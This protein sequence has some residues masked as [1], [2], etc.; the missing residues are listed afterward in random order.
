MSAARFFGDDHAP[1]INFTPDDEELIKLYLLPRV[2]GEPDPFPGL[3][4]DDD[5]AATTQPWT[6]FSR[7]H[8]PQKDALPAFFYVRTPDARS[9]RRCDGGG[10]W[11]SQRRV[12]KNKNKDDSHALLVGGEKIRWIR[13]NLNF[14]MGSGSIGWVMREYSIPDHPFL[15][16]CRISF[17]G[18]GQKRMRVPDDSSLAAG[19]PATKRARVA[20]AADGGSAS[21]TTTTSFDQEIV[22]AGASSGD[23][24]PTQDCY[25]GRNNGVAMVAEMTYAQPSWEFQEQQMQTMGQPPASAP[26]EPAA[27]VFFADQDPPSDS[28][29]AT[30]LNGGAMVAD[31]TYAQPSW[32]FQE[33]QV[34]TMEQPP[35]A[36]QEPAAQVFFA[37]QDPPSD[38]RTA[39]MLNGGVMVADMTYAQ[40]SWEFQ[41]Q[42]PSSAAQEPPAH[43]FSAEQDPPSASRM[44][45][46][47]NQDSSAGLEL[48]PLGFELPSDEEFM[49]M[50]DGLYNL[51]DVYQQRGEQ[52][53]ASTMEQKADQDGFLVPSFLCGAQDM[54]NMFVTANMDNV[55]SFL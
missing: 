21:W 19:E 41:E 9:V 17:S 5:E 51:P 26:Q 32:E 13:H 4:I 15:K 18:H 44:A 53:Q 30:M 27:H 46:M 22:E 14:D 48:D 35:S 1:G 29:T 25:D 16:V 6:L 11:K 39:T 3:I 47:L 43:V 54:G 2:R 10:T 33:Q 24:E 50:M 45:T 34:Q 37:D 36:A 49:K 28:R 12:G 7:H 42:P 31:M 20:A 55:P 52:A 8:L 40:P 38:S 23:Q